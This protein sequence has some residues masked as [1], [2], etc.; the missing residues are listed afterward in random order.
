MKA[1][2]RIA[3][4][5]DDHD[6]LYMNRCVLEEQ[7]FQVSCFSDP[8]VAIEAMNETT[9]DIIVTDLMMN[10]MTSGFT[11]LKMIRS[12]ETL[13]SIPVIIVTAI[14]SKMGFDFSPRDETDLKAMGA[15]AYFSKPVDHAA[16][17]SR[18]RELLVDS[19]QEKR[20]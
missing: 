15:Q 6:F 20:R 5:D 18:I 12:D 17:L 4:I 16:F 9:P 1:K 7:G 14:G 2:S 8:L 11:F 13:R 3:L 19:P 10:K